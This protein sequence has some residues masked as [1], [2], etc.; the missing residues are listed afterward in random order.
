M[1]HWLKVNKRLE[2]RSLRER[3]F[4]RLISRKYLGKLKRMRLRTVLYV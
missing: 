4:L 1:N 3:L 2:L